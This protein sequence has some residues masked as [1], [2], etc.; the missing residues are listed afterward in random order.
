MAK[1]SVAALR[2]A[3]PRPRRAAPLTDRLNSRVLQTLRDLAQGL[4]EDPGIED[5]YEFEIFGNLGPPGAKKH[6]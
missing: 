3:T 5:E 2:L 6:S 4:E 1:H